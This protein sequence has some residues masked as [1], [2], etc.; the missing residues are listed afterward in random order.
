MSFLIL[1][2][3]F[4]F[5]SPPRANCPAAVLLSK[6]SLDSPEPNFSHPLE[7]TWGD[8]IFSY[9]VIMPES[10]TPPL[11]RDTVSNL[12]TFVLT[13]PGQTSNCLP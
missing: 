4:L 3:T 12:G 8:L 7:C 11:V 9:S 13:S 6:V 10:P 1:E 5:Y 2:P